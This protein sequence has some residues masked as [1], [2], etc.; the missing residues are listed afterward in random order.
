MENSERVVALNSKTKPKNIPHIF[1]LSFSIVIFI[2]FMLYAGVALVSGR[3]LI[4]LIVPFLASFYYLSEYVNDGSLY[5]KLGKKTNIGLLLIF[6]VLSISAGILFFLEY[7]AIQNYAWYEFS[8]L[9]LVLAFFILFLVME[10]SRREHKILFFINLFFILYCLPQVGRLFPEP[11]FHLGLPY[12]R[13]ITSN[14]IEGSGVLGD[15]P[16]IGFYYAL[17]MLIFLGIVTGFGALKSLGEIVMAYARRRRLLPPIGI[18]TSAAIGVTTASIT[19]NV[20]VAGSYTIP[21]YKT[22]GFS[23]DYAGA[24]EVASSVGGLILPPIMSVVA[25]VMAGVM[26]V[27]YWDVVTH[28]WIIG[29]IYFIALIVCVDL[30]GRKYIS[31]STP[32]EFLGR[33]SVEKSAF[34]Y[35]GGFILALAVIIIYLGVFMFEIP[36]A[37]YYGTITLLVYFFIVKISEGKKCGFRKSLIDFLKHFF[38][39]VE[40]GAVDACNVLLLVAVLGVMLNVM[41]ATG[42]LADVSWVLAGIAKASPYLLV[43]TAYFFGLIVGLGLPPTATYISMAILFVPLML[44]AGFNFWSAHF[45]AFLIACLAEFSPPASIAAA[46]AARMSGGS[47]YKIMTISSLLSLP[48]WIFP[49]ICVLFPQVL[50]LTPEGA[51][52]GLITLTACLGLTIRFLCFFLKEKIN[53]L[54][55]V[56]LSINVILGAVIF[57]SPNMLVDL[58]STVIIWVLLILAYKKL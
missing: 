28:S 25:F 18:V 37:A 41:T 21:M 19:A 15:L 20:T 31:S 53:M 57:V 36:T 10:F 45:F 2:I 43:I 16:G 27:S 13:I 12:V 9:D 54:S 17:P 49:F 6:V 55:S 39:S 50:T 58:I 56:L 44:E 3:Q 42:F 32:S 4:F 22:I 30:I 46:A 5:P 52:Y 38:R 34:L 24:I 26:G 40:E 14:T 47:F 35:F 51:L 7:Y 48:I 11:F 1:L 8:L 33:R 23:S 29:F